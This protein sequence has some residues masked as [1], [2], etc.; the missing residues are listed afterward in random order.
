MTRFFFL[1][2]KPIVKFP[3]PLLHLNFINLCFRAMW[4]KRMKVNIICNW[5]PRSQ[6]IDL[7]KICGF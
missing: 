6:A 3:V 7:E 4:E 2:P 5:E 1:S